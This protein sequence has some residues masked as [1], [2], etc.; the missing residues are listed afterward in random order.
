LEAV[1]QEKADVSGHGGF[2]GNIVIYAKS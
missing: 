1:E 2:R